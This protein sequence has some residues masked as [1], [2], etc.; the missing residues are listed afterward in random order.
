MVVVVGPVVVEVEV[1]VVVDVVE[2]DVDVVGRLQHWPG[3][4]FPDRLTKQSPMAPT[5]LAQLAGG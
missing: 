3:K 4:R 2:V 1:T 5:G